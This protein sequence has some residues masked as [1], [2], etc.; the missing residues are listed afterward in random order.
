MLSNFLSL[1]NAQFNQMEHIQRASFMV[2]EIM[3]AEEE[4][5]FITGMH[6]IFDMKDY[7]MNHFTSMPISMI[8]KLK[9]CWEV[10]IQVILL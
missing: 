10:F 5:M 4:Q 1:I 6:L 8:K 3:G 2:W 9:P 7:T